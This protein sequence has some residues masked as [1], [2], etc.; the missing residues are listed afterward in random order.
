MVNV[1]RGL[2]SRCALFSPSQVI[3]ADRSDRCIY[4]RRTKGGG[5]ER[6]KQ[7]CGKGEEGDRNNAVCLVLI[8]ALA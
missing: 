1:T 6:N 3:C 4:N 5:V 8:G 2:E 7:E